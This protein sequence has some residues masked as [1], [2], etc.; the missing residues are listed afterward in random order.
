MYKVKEIGIEEIGGARV[1]SDKEI[2]IG[3][4]GGCQSEKCL[5]RDEKMS[6]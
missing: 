3:E 6:F 1:K 4:I 5:L 2:G